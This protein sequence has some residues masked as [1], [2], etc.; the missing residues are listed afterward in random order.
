MALQGPQ[1]PYKEV[2]DETQ[3]RLIRALRPY[4]AF[5]GLIEI[6]WQQLKFQRQQPI[7]FPSKA[8]DD[9]LLK[10]IIIGG[11]LNV[12]SLIF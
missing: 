5:K 7:G 4:K 12:K 3:K 6:L 10:Y 9:P 11:Y 1:G 8:P 2:P